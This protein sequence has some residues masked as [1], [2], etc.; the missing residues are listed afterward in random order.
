MVVRFVQS[1]PVGVALS[2]LLLLGACA[3]VEGPRD[4]RLDR[5]NI[6]SAASNNDAYA[7]FVDELRMQTASAVRRERASRERNLMLMSDLSEAQA[8]E[9]ALS[10]ELN[11]LNGQVAS[12][13]SLAETAQAD[14]AEERAKIATLN[15]RRA[16][17]NRRANE[18]ATAPQADL[19][20]LEDE[21][22]ALEAERRILARE[23]ESLI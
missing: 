15:D 13:N 16:E 5:S 20:A 2:A 10:A 23:Y 7:E 11:A 14:S 22:T 12:L 19:E 17:L 8:R 9:Q 3:S 4:P 18:L 1:R 21:L 6:Y